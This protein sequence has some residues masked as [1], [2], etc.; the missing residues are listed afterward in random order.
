MAECVFCA[1]LA[2]TEPAEVIFEDEDTIAFLDIGPATEGHTLVVPRQHCVDLFDIGE[3]R[4][5]TVM[6]S[7]IEVAG[8]LKTALQPD[9]MNL[10]HASGETAWQSVFHFHLHLIPRYR[11]DE[12]TQPWPIGR[13]RADREELT[14]VAE[15]I[16]A[17]GLG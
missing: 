3:D 13:R 9:G 6:R 12:L 17:V 1:I 16:R 10:V 5:A 15:R 14:T 2:G 7:A 11:I 8:L 4:A